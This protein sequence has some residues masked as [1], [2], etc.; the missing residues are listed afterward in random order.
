ML[1]SWHGRA[2]FSDDCEECAVVWEKREMANQ[3]LQSATIEV[4]LKL[5]QVYGSRK[6]CTIWKAGWHGSGSGNSRSR[7]LILELLRN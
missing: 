3:E 7:N 4:D 5:H 2:Q 6:E 1:E